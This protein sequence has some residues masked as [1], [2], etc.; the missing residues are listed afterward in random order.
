MIPNNSTTLGGSVVK[1]YSIADDVA[2][3]HDR[4]FDLISAVSPGVMTLI[5]V[6]VLFSI[7]ILLLLSVRAAINRIGE[8]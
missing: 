1:F 3:I 5:L 4:L 7:V 6:T 2:L 8:I